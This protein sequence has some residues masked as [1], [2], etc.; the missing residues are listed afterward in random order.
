MSCWSWLLRQ[1]MLQMTVALS[2]F[3]DQSQMGAV[4]ARSAACRCLQQ[5]SQPSA[6]SPKQHQAQQ[7][8]VEHHPQ[9]NGPVSSA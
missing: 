6:P 9:L 1:S 3:Q 2:L 8:Q 5:L 7:L 4:K